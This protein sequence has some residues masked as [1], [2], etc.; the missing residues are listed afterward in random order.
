MYETTEDG[1]KFSLNTNSG[2]ES[3]V[4]YSAGESKAGTG[5]SVPD[6]KEDEKNLFQITYSPRMFPW[7]QAADSRSSASST[8]GIGRCAKC[9]FI[10]LALALSF[11]IVVW[12]V[13]LIAEGPHELHSCVIL[14]P[15]VAGVLIISAL[16][17]CLSGYDFFMKRR[18]E[19]ENI[20][21]GSPLGIKAS[22]DIY[23]RA[24]EY[25]G[26]ERHSC[27]EW[28]YLCLVF[29]LL[30]FMIASVEQYFSLDA[31]CYSYLKSN[32]DDLLLGYE[33]LAYI[34]VVVL[35]LLGCFIFLIF[36]GILVYC[37]NRNRKLIDSSSIS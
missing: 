29:A 19:R 3:K 7:R 4:E 17:L 23:L 18:K 1:A 10:L 35:S 24:G 5:I 32:I 22:L 37:G 9:L 28:S 33:V 2:L 21:R 26:Y 20:K 27:I 12:V 34:S 16:F 13:A 25:V 6:S 8:R 36:V 14:W 11:V 31:S 15:I 30:C